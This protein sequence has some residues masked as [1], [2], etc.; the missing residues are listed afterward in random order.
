MKNKDIVEALERV[1]AAAEVELAILIEQM[2]DDGWEEYDIQAI[3]YA[4]KDVQVAL[5][6]IADQFP[7]DTPPRVLQK[8]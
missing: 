6:R 5:L 2:R 1:Q 8:V 3:E 4:K 7:T